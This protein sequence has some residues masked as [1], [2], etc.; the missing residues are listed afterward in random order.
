[1]VVKMTHKENFLKGIISENPVLFSLLGLCPLLGIT[2]KLEN[3]IGMGLAIIFVMVLSNLIVSL[4]RNI[5]PHEIRI[6]I[7]IVII[8]SFVT[9]VDMVMAAFLTELHETLGIFIPLIVV[10]CM[11]LGRAEAFASKNTALPSIIDGLGM[12]IGYTI[13]LAIVSIVREFLGTGMITVWGNLALDIN[14][15][16]GSEKFAIF[17]SFFIGEAGAYIVIGLLFGIFSAIQIKRKKK[18][19]NA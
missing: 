8:A 7:Y 14:A 15:L 3:A 2:T 9:I 12:A 5:V 16:F 11:I 18:A 13:V 19:G 6:P 4:I 17:S 10:N 1:M